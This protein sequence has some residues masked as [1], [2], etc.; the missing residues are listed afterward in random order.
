[1]GLSRNPSRL[2]RPFDAREALTPFSQGSVGCQGREKAWHVRGKTGHA[3]SGQN[4]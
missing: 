4:C 2:S 3:S 1:M